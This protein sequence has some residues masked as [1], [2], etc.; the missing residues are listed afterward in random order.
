MPLYY[1]TRRLTSSRAAARW[2]GAFSPCTRCRRGRQAAA[3]DL[4][5]TTTLLIA[6]AIGYV[7]ILTCAGGAGGA[8]PWGDGAARSMVV[9]VE[10]WPRNM[11]LSRRGGTRAA[12]ALTTRS[13]SRR[14]RAHYLVSWSVLGD[15][16]R[17]QPHIGNCPTARR[18]CRLATIS[19]L[20]EP[21][22]T[23]CCS[24]ARPRSIQTSAI[25]ARVRR[26]LTRRVRAH[27]ETVG[28]AAPENV[29]IAY[30]CRPRITPYESQG[31]TRAC[32]RCDTVVGRRRL[33]AR[34]V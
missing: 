32:A 1:L 23:I 18:S 4:A 29:D 12:L 24:R 25:V 15:A 8:D 10:G 6:F 20:L 14:C 9:P 27:G 5:I 34:A 33:A 16:K 22:H 3:S 26:I 30:L 13:P 2:A 28:D 7:R 19:I 11:L 21:R 17:R 31:L